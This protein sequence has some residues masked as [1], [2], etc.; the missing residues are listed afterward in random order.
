MVLPCC[1]LGCWMNSFIGTCPS[2]LSNEASGVF[3]SWSNPCSGCLS[4]WELFLVC[5]VLPMSVFQ[6]ATEVSQNPLSWSS[7]LVFSLGPLSVVASSLLLTSCSPQY[8][9]KLCFRV[10]PRLQEDRRVREPDEASSLQDLV[11]GVDIGAVYLQETLLL[12]V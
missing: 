5:C 6:G 11:D 7:L 4:L 8:F 2:L 10:P 1:F 3:V 12:A 9:S